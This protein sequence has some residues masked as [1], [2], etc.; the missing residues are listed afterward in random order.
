MLPGLIWT[1][2]SVKKWGN[3]VW[4][5]GA[6]TMN[7]L[8]KAFDFFYEKSNI[9]FE[10]SRHDGNPSYHITFPNMLWLPKIF[11]RTFPDTT[12]NSLVDVRSIFG[13][14][15][16]SSLSIEWHQKQRSRVILSEKNFI[17]S[18]NI[19]LDNSV[20]VRPIALQN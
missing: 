2:S 11:V 7:Y 13:H 8:V 4:Q 20:S 5:K 16:A 6:G 1:L 3:S 10:I 18:F 15:S 9:S 19:S 12:K 14:W 17:R